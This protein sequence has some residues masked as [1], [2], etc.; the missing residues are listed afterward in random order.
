MPI[1]DYECERCRCTF[2]RKQRYDE[3]PTAIC[4]CGGKARRVLHS[5]PIIFKGSGFYVTDHGKRGTAESTGSAGKEPTK[6]PVASQAKSSTTEA[7]PSSPEN[8]TAET[9]PNN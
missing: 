5:V 8:K 2:E 1:Y 4:E 3:E 7:K 6:E 9:K